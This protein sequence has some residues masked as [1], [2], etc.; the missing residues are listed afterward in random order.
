MMSLREIAEIRRIT[1]TAFATSEGRMVALRAE[2]ARINAQIA[3]L[4]D[5]LRNRATVAT[6]EDAALRAGVDLRW[7]QWVDSR[8]RNLLS[9]LA[10]LRARIE[11]EREILMRD[12]GR[13]RVAA[14]IAGQ[15]AAAQRAKR[16]SRAERGW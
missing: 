11:A 10:R 9:E 2:E 16:E 4:D 3:S 8:R 7:Q 13:D 1:E 5:A 15:V 12:F 14:D 6:A